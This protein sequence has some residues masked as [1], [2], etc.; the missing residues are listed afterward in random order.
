[1]EAR[2]VRNGGALLSPARGFNFTCYIEVLT[3]I[4]AEGGIEFFNEVADAWDVINPESRIHWSKFNRLM[5]NLVPRL[6]RQY[7]SALEEFE[8]IR[9]SLNVDPNK[10][11]FN[12]FF[13]DLL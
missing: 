13:D 10:M 6:R 3:G 7:G 8:E 2:F 11:F 12:S 1:M 5:P 4:D 9:E